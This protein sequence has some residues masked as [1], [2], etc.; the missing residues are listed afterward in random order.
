MADDE[1]P[2]DSMTIELDQRRIR[3]SGPPC[4]L[5]DVD[6][7]AHTLTVQADGFVPATRRVTVGRGEHVDL[8][9]RLS[10][11]HVPLGDLLVHVGFTDPDLVLAL[12]GKRIGALPQKVMDIPVGP[13]RLRIEG[14]RHQRFEQSIEIEDRKQLDIVPSLGV[15]EGTLT[16]APGTDAEGLEV[17]LVSMER[18]GEA[19]RATTTRD[20]PTLRCGALSDRHPAARCDE[21][22]VFCLRRRTSRSHDHDQCSCGAR[23][24][25]STSASSRAR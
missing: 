14:P 22:S 13:H 10:R 2:I 12:D 8:S 20:A 7:G 24:G 11:R 3:C 19:P 16:L 21:R 18:P 5:P 17:T 1:T 4:D 9:L 15:T 6:A 25:Q 23:E